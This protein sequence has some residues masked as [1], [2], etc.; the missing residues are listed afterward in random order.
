M[1]PETSFHSSVVSMG[2]DI[3]LVMSSQSNEVGS[4]DGREELNDTFA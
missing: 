3:Q 4:Q 1:Y 2:V